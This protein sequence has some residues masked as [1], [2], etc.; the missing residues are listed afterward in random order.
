MI[1]AMVTFMENIAKES[2]ANCQSNTADFAE[3]DCPPERVKG[4]QGPGSST[5]PN[6][7]SGPPCKSVTMTYCQM[8]ETVQLE[9]MEENL[10]VDYLVSEI[11]SLLPALWVTEF[12]FHLRP[13]G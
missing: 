5:N 8:P 6:S 7:V 13:L 1:A 9:I 10:V 12:S 4:E 11:S 3:G 2:G